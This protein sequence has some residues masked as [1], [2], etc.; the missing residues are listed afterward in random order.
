VLRRD[1]YS[2]TLTVSDDTARFEKYSDAY[3]DVMRSLT[4]ESPEEAGADTLPREHS[5]E[6]VAKILEKTPG[7][8]WGRAVRRDKTVIEP[9]E[10][11]TSDTALVTGEEARGIVA[12]AVDVG[13]AQ[14]CGLDWKPPYFAAQQA[15]REAGWGERRM[16]YA[17]V[18][19]GVSQRS[20]H[21]RA[22]RELGVCGPKQRAA[23]RKRLERR[24][25]TTTDE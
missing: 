16:A 10:G 13:L 1:G 6:A 22:R 25:D 5:D 11:E 17:A 24:E 18:L 14:W 12:E 23:V 15:R 19:F 8:F 9:G 4:M 2:I 3:L 20:M 21:S 7:L